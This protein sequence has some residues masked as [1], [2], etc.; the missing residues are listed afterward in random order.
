MAKETTG[1]T[2][3]KQHKP[4]GIDEASPREGSAP[5][6]TTMGSKRC[7]DVLAPR[8]TVL[9]KLP[10]GGECGA[11]AAGGQRS[12]E[13]IARVRL[14]KASKGSLRTRCLFVL[15]T[16]LWWSRIASPAACYKNV[17]RVASGWNKH[18]RAQVETSEPGECSAVWHL[19]SDE[20]ATSGSIKE[21]RLETRCTC[22]RRKG[23]Y[24]QQ[25][26]LRSVES[27]RLHR[28]RRCLGLQRAKAS[29]TRDLN[30][31]HHLGER[32]SLLDGSHLRHLDQYSSGGRGGGK[33]WRRCKRM[34]H[35]QEAHRKYQSRQQR[36]SPFPPLQEEEQHQQPYHNRSRP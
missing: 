35:Q 26:T 8:D 29:C 36:Q 30:S 4:Q 24:P 16:H 17:G 6:K 27:A 2:P 12:V 19:R 22:H 14:A 32:P 15:F 21:Q 5:P 10:S 7:K 33:R 9:P 13:V 31:R 11:P 34:P 1:P 23:R 25:R 18:T 28:S 3:T 20:V